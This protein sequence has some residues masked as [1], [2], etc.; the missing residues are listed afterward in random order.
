MTSADGVPALVMSCKVISWYCMGVFCTVGC[1]VRRAIWLN[2]TSTCALLH[3]CYCFLKHTFR[4]SSK[5][6][7]LSPHVQ[8][9]TMP[10]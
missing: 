9:A 6:R 10:F 8:I 2:N 4:K 1:W 7:E 3:F 5:R